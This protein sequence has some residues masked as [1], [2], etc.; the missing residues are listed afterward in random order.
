MSNIKNLYLLDIADFED[1]EVVKVIVNVGDYV[2]EYESIIIIENDKATTEIPTSFSG[3]VESIK[4]AVGDK[5]SKGDLIAKFIID[6]TD[7]NISI[8]KDFVS[9]EHNQ[10]ITMT[11]SIEDNNKFYASPSIRKL[12]RELG[13]NLSSIKG[14]GTKGRIIEKD[15]KDY[16]KNTLI[17]TVE[18]EQKIESIAI[19]KSKKLSAQHIINCWQNIPHITQFDEVN[20]DQI[21]EFRL[22]QESRGVKL[23]PLAFVMKALVGVLKNNPQFNASLD[24]DGLN[25]LVKKYYNFGFVVYSS[26]GAVVPVITDVDKKSL[27][28]ITTEIDELT[29]KAKTATLLEKSQ[30]AGFTLL[31]LGEF[32]TANFTSI[33]HSSQV[34]ILG[35]SKI[36]IK[37]HW[38]GKAFVPTNIMPLSLSYDSR[39]I[40]NFQGAKFIT[41]INYM[42]KNIMEILL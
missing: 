22:D 28:D 18:T 5:I 4:V 25:I 30:E 16:I 35:L 9:I 2:K 14:S 20:V 3:K 17:D 42:L 19:T 11:K 21:E 12:A 40:D 24:K 29:E 37:P 1:I 32:A 36:Q 41:E 13:V 6:N 7:D 31:D 39:V 33:I 26:D 27:I 34:A 8:K 15:L 23:S 38:D 10:N